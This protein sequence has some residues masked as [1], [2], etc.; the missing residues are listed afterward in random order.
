MRKR[1]FILLVVVALLMCSLT[2]CGAVAKSADDAATEMSNFKVI[3]GKEYLA[4]SV[5]TR[6]VYYMFITDRA[7]GNAGYG[8]TYFA[9]YISE[10]GNFCRYI[11]D[12]IVEITAED[13]NN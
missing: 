7:V 13:T 1:T 5:D 2:A 11:N 8:Y 12:E 10:N 9:P 3:E 6:V 4:Y